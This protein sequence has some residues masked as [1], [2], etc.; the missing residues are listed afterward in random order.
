MPGLQMLEKAAVADEGGVGGGSGDEKTGA[1]IE[2]T[3]TEK[4]GAEEAPSR[5]K[6]RGGSGPAGFFRELALE[7]K[8]G[9]VIYFLDVAADVGIGI[10][11]QVG[12]QSGAISPEF[13]VAMFGT[14][15]PFPCV[16]TEEAQHTVGIPVAVG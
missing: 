11:E 2:K 9:E 10:V 4:V 14:A 1:A 8:I 3:K 16:A 15:G 7:I 12:V 13:D 6:N 5:A